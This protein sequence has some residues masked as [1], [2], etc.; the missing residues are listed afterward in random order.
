MKKIMLP[1]LAVVL[2]AACQNS[3]SSTTEENASTAPT[4]IKID[5][6]EVSQANTKAKA[7]MEVIKNFLTEI[8]ETVPNLTKE[9]Q[10]QIDN[11]RNEVNEVIAKQDQMIK[12]LTM[13]ETGEGESS[14][15][16]DMPAMPTPGVIQDYIQSADNYGKFIEDARSRFE[17]IKAGKDN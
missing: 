14:P 13:A 4:E 11:L 3:N 16:T 6:A 1:F 9:E 8:N 12:G 5:A 17:A 2:F 15:E 7:T 10:T